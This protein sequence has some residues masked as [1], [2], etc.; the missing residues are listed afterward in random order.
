MVKLYP[1]YEIGSMAKPT[2]RTRGYAGRKLRPKD[3]EYAKKWGESLDLDYSALEKVLKGDDPDR[4]NQIV[5]WSAL[6]VLTMFEKA[7]LDIVYDGEQWRVEM[8]EH[9]IRKLDGFKFSGWIKSFD[10]R[11]FKKASVVEKVRYDKPYYIAEYEAVKKQTDLPLKV[12][13]TG[14]YTLTDWTYNNYYEKKHSNIK[15]FPHRRHEARK[16]LIYDLVEEALRPEFKKLVDAGVKW[17]QIDEPA[18]TTKESPEEME[19]FVDAYNRCTEGFDIKFS[20][21]NCFSNYDLLA[22][23]VPHLKNCSQLSLEYA[24]RDT[25]SEGEKHPG[26]DGL[27]TFLDNGYEGAYAPGFLDVHTN[28]METPELVKDRILYVSDI[29]GKDKV[30]VTPDCGLRTRSWEIAYEKLCNL[31]RGAELARDQV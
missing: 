9:I 31:T 26:Y 25:H 19:L 21:H 7:G 24:N 2:W 12:P 13:I 4:K 23:Y 18:V 11:Y 27:A 8:Y 5:N 28:F 17:I 14:P 6:Y 20:L 30:W 29:V 22:E 16:D 15:S 3:F 10:Y 1:T